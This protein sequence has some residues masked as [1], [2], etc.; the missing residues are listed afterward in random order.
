MQGGGSIVIP[1]REKLAHT[2]R[3]LD[4]GGWADLGPFH[5]TFDQLKDMR[6]GKWSPLTDIGGSGKTWPEVTMDAWEYRVPEVNQGI[7]EDAHGVTLWHQDGD[8][9][10]YILL[11]TNDYPTELKPRGI[12]SAGNGREEETRTIIPF[13]SHMLLIHNKSMLHRTPEDYVMDA[14]WHRARPRHFL[15]S[16]PRFTYGRDATID[17]WLRDLDHI[18]T[19]NPTPSV[20]AAPSSVSN[21]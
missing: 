18:A 7:A 17:Q 20:L 13:P 1:P 6:R 3:K 21:V 5:P 9:G 19:T 15:R 11:W 8:F 16:Y 12:K 10:G 4:T 14:R 2:I